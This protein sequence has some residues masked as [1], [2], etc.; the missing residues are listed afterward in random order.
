MRE[1]FK[2][3]TSHSEFYMLVDSATGLG[4][5]GLVYTNMTGSYTRTRSARVAV[6]MA[7]QTVAGA[8]SSGGFVEIDATNQPGLYRWDHPDAAYAD[9][10]DSVVFSLKATGVRTEHK[11]FRLVNTNNQI[12][13]YAAL[14]MAAADL[15]EQLDAINALAAAIPT[16]PMLDTED[17]SSLTNIPD[18]ATLA[19]Q[20]EIIGDIA[21]AQTA[22]DAIPTNPMLADADGSSFG[23]IPDMAT[24][25][26]VNAIKA[27]TDQLIFTIPNQIDANALSGAGGL[28]ASGIRAAIGL[29]EAN[30]DIQLE[31]LPTLNEL[32]SR[33]RGAF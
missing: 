33:T 22:I 13:S 24:A 18:M 7:M 25:T 20:E 5:T 11:E 26:S 8:F 2:G 16:N 6:T 12:T 14:G 23:A 30:L 32:N 19:K 10:A 1:E 31:V 4:K 21:I 9:G 3:S 29:D 17:G 28:D 15:D 27:K